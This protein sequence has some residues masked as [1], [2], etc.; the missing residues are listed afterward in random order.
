MKKTE[1]NLMLLLILE[2]K[3]DHFRKEFQM[4]A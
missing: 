2:E 1:E 3:T 4:L